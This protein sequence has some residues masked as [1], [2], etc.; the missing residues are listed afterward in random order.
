MVGWPHYIF[1][2]SLIAFISEIPSGIYY[3]LQFVILVGRGSFTGFLLD[4]SIIL[5]VDLL[6]YL[7]HVSKKLMETWWE[8]EEVKVQSLAHAN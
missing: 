4:F 3:L 2:N 1:Q 7:V 8:Q 5:S 6:T